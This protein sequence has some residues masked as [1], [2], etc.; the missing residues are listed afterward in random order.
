MSGI[1]GPTGLLVSEGCDL[2]VIARSAFYDS[3]AEVRDDTT[4]VEAIAAVCEGFESNGWWRIRAAF[5]RQG[6]FANHKK[7][8]RL[9]EHGLTTP[10]R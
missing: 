6:L 2:M 9:H 4:V 5:G 7:I 10:Y 1:T 8:R 3:E